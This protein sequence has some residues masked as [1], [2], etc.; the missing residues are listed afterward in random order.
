MK[1]MAALAA[2]VLSL[3]AV[4][5][6]AREIAIDLSKHRIEITAGFDGAELL[7]F[8]HDSSGAEVIVIVRGPPETIAVREKKRTVGIWINQNRMVFERT[9]SFYYVATT[10]GLRGDGQLDSI[11]ASTGLGPRYLGLTPRDGAESGADDLDAADHARV[12]EFRTALIN[13]RADQ[14]LYSKAPGRI[15]MRKDRLFR[16]TVPFP[17]VTPVG[18]YTVI[19]YEIVD[20]WPVISAETP[21]IVQ[22]AGFGAFVY[23]AAHDHPAL[24]GVIAIL[25]A[26]VAGWLGGWAFRKS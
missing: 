19:V 13:I 15:I 17:A 23:N 6:D 4:T 22:K 12:E 7:L 5:A 3:V 9:P 8:G 21:L 20:G 1:M 16:T 2:V 14:Q 26:L 25:I 24:Y 10:D 11:L 18:E